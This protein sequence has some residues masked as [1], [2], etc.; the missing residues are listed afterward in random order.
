MSEVGVEDRTGESGKKA[1]KRVVPR[2]CNKNSPKVGHG[3]IW[4]SSFYYKVRLR[5]DERDNYNC[6]DN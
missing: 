5:G 3:Y 1:G 2:L 6:N 4:L